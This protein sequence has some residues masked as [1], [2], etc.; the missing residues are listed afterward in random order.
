MARQVLDAAEKK[1]SDM[2]HKQQKKLEIA[3]KSLIKALEAKKKEFLGIL[4]D[5]YQEQ[6]TA[7]SFERGKALN[8]IQ[9]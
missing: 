9:G 3:Y 8:L 2:H 6:R 1:L 7:V 4:R 5:F